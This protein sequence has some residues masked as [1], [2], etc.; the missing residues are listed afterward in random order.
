[1]GTDSFYGSTI[2]GCCRDCQ[3]RYPACHDY[4]ERYQDARSEWIDHKRKV[5]EALRPDEYDQRKFQSIEEMRK[6]RK[7]HDR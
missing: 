7:W 5:K 1:M 6:R 4:C 2:G 3:D